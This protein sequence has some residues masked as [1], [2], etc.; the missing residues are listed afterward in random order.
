MESVKVGADSINQPNE[1]NIIW[2][3]KEDGQRYCRPSKSTVACEPW[4]K[5]ELEKRAI[6]GFKEAGIGACRPPEK[7]EV[8]ESQNSINADWRGQK[9]VG[10]QR[11]G[12][13]SQGLRMEGGYYPAG[14][15]MI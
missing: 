8:C 10:R 15:L 2:I 11:V 13:R 3:I 14:W 1:R 12:Q 5:Y 4:Q 6:C 9:L 7:T